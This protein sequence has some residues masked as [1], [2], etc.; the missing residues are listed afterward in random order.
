MKKPSKLEY[1]AA[2]HEAGRAQ[3]ALTLGMKFEEDDA[4]CCER[5][6][7][8]TIWELMS[9]EK[10]PIAYVHTAGMTGYSNEAKVALSLAG[11]IAEYRVSQADPLSIGGDAIDMLHTISD[12]FD[13][14]P[15]TTKQD[16]RW[17]A[18]AMR[19]SFYVYESVEEAKHDVAWAL[20]TKDHDDIEEANRS[21]A[22]FLLYGDRDEADK[23]AEDVENAVLA[24]CVSQ[25]TEDARKMLEPRVTAEPYFTFLAEAADKAR[26][27]LNERWDI[28]LSLA[29]HLLKVGRMS[30]AELTAFGQATPVHAAVAN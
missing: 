11:G 14:L 9:N 17:L 1:S 6:T 23:D 24:L 22:L 25:N 10:H 5:G 26:A 30:A 7:G 21:A 27:I 18:A 15:P 12:Q 4:I 16:D 19:E 28:V 29:T 13:K 8:M 20:S 2:V 3:V